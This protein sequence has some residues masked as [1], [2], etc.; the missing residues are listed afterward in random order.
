MGPTVTKKE[1]DDR[2]FLDR[3]FENAVALP[4]DSD[5]DDDEDDD[6]EEEEDLF[7]VMNDLNLT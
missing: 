6:D 4:V 7:I 3:A 2:G 1:R 5:D